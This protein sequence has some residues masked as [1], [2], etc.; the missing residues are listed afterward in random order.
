L[1][2]RGELKTVHARLKEACAAAASDLYALPPVADAARTARTEFDEVADAAG[3]C[4]SAGRLTAK[5]AKTKNAICIGH[6]LPKLP[7]MFAPSA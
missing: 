6:F 2:Q 4:A 7:V 1:R 3:C 5:I